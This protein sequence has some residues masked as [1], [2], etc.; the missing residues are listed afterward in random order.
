MQWWSFNET[1]SE[2]ELSLWSAC[3]FKILQ[4]LPDAADPGNTKHLEPPDPAQDIDMKRTS[5]L[6]NH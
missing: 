4:E 3:A 1:T 2:D 5:D 6:D